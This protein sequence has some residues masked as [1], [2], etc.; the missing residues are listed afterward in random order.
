V[1]AAAAR[2]VERVLSSPDALALLIER[3]EAAGWHVEREV[4]AGAAPGGTASVAGP[5]PRDR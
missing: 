3:L 5:G 2:A 1:R 4:P